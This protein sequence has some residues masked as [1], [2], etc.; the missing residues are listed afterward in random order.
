M[1]LRIRQLYLKTD[2]KTLLDHTTIDI[3]AGCIHTLSGCNGAGKTSL[4]DAIADGAPRYS[5]IIMWQSQDV[6][7]SLVAYAE[8]RAR[9]YNN[10]TG[11]DY[12]RFLGVQY[13][14]LAEDLRRAFGLSFDIP[15]DHLSYG[16]MR[17]LQFIGALAED[18]PITLLDEPF[19]GM[20]GTARNTIREA[21]LQYRSPHK[22]IIVA[23]AHEE[24]A[25][26][27][28]D[29]LLKMENGALTMPH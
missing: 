8:Q 2:R 15:T 3:A 18:R 27:F 11:T 1:C 19:A 16:Q 26:A 7:A 29:V 6:D 22:V 21:L 25:A 24:E 12:L 23:M 17:Q 28:G 9:L 4:L 14:S 13:S 5:D 10:M 20:C